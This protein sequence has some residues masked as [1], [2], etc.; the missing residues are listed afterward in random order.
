LR[1]PARPAPE[2]VLREV[3]GLAAGRGPQRGAVDAVLA[4]RDAL[5]TMPTGA[6]KSLVYQLPALVLD[7]MT[8]V[9]SPLIALMK[10]QVDALV[11]RGIAA[12]FV[13]SS[14]E[15]AERK[16]RLERA[17]RGELDLLYVTPERFRSPAFLEVLPRL[18][19]TRIAVDEAHCIS[20]WGHDFRPDYW[21]LGEYRAL[22]GDPPT[23]ALTATA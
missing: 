7:G 22:C 4:G 19:I 23:V 17:A 9:V 10:D 16:R 15:P 11:A 21:R 1:T 2:L 8:L 14:L 3:F 12:A 20:Q 5:V 18:A 13:N 6:G